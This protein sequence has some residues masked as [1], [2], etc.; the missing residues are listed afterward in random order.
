MRTAG[1]GAVSATNVPRTAI[2]ARCSAATAARV[3]G[4]SR[5]GALDVVVAD[6]ATGAQPRLED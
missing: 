2:V 5:G 1:S 3:S 6:D 4:S